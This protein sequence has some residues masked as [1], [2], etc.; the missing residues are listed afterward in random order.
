MAATLQDNKRS[1]GRQVEDAGLGTKDGTR[2]MLGGCHSYL[3]R[4]VVVR[5]RVD[6]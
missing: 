2:E 5:A 4:E 1:T 3:V 6:G